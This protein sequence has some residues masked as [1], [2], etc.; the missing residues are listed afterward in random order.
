MS[1]KRSVPVARHVEP[2]P[3]ARLVRSEDA[4]E[5]NFPCASCG[6]SVRYD[7]ESQGLKCEY[8]GIRDPKDT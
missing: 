2:V 6:A 1:D 7:P 4:R 5:K 3:M 8:C